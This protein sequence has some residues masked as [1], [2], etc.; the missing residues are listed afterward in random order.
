MSRYYRIEV[1]PGSNGLN[2]S[3]VSKSVW[4]NQVN[5]MADIGAQMVELDVWEYA[6]D[7]PIGAGA[8]TIWGPSR[9]Q[10]SQAADYNGSSIKVYAGMQNGLPLATSAVADGQQGLILSGQVFQA[11]GNWQGVNQTL[12]FVVTPY[13]GATQSDPSNLSVKWDQGVPMADLIRNVLN[14]AFPGK[15]VTINISPALILSQTDGFVYQTLQTF[16]DYVRRV[17]KQIIN[18]DTYPGVSIV[19]RDNG[20]VVFDG[21]QPT[22]STSA[23][24]TIRNKDLIGAPTWLNANEIQFNTV[25][26]AD[27]RV[28]TRIQF[29]RTQGQALAGVAAYT[30]A[31][32]QSN[33]R[34]KNT[35][36]GTWTIK[37]VRSVGNSRAPDAQSWITTF[38][39]YSNTA[40]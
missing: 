36:Q 25:M 10:I 16:A 29:E 32:S 20:F 6:L 12:N 3:T 17:S 21:T 19:A 1:T 7:T 13:A 5:G 39:A 9:E 35:F 8:V 28:G 34:A 27:L 24:I 11:F 18:S 15:T 37:V 40:L 26:R 30:T 23:T 33:A 22:A 4:T 38:Q 31:A 14:Q 2:T